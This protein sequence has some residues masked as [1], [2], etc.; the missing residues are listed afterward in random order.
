MVI[1][2]ETSPFVAGYIEQAVIE[3]L[4]TFNLI[5]RQVFI[6]LVITGIWDIIAHLRQ[7]VLMPRLV[8]PAH[9]IKGRLAAKTIAEVP[10]DGYKDRLVKYIPAESIAMYTFADK[11]LI[12]HYGINAAG[13]ATSVPAD[14]VLRVSAWALFLL[15]LIGTPIYTGNAFQINP[16]RCTL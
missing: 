13:V 3:T 4:C 14:S 8:I 7:E 11:L 6:F 12:S 5:P 2:G 9:P 15:G 10:T 16:G 1:P